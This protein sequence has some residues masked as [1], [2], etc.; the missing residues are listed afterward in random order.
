MNKRLS[1][2]KRLNH[3]KLPIKVK[4][5]VITLILL[6]IPMCTLGIMSF[7]KASTELESKGETILINAVNSSMQLIELA[8]TEVDS[9]AISLEE[10]QE[11][12]KTLLIGEKN[13]DGSRT[14]KKTIDLGGNGF[15]IILDKEANVL[16]H[17]EIEGENL[18][19]K[20][21]KSTT[22]ILFARELIEKGLN[23]GGFTEYNLD[24]AG[25]VDLNIVYSKVDPTWGWIVSAGTYEDN[26]DES[27]NYILNMMYLI[28]LLSFIIGTFVIIAFARHICNPLKKLTILVEKTK[29]LDLSNDDAYNK[30]IKNK[31][32]V[33]LMASS[34]LEMRLS[35]RSIVNN[36]K[37]GVEETFNSSEVL[38]IAANETASCS[39]DIANT[40]DILVEGAM[41]QAYESENGTNEL[42]ILGEEIHNTTIRV[43][44]VKEIIDLTSTVSEKGINLI[45]DLALKSKNKHNEST[46]VR[47][48]VEELSYKSS[49]IDNMLELITQIASQTNI[50]ALNASIE[51]AR[52]GEEGKGFTVVANEVKT[53]AETTDKTV[54]D[55]KAIVNEM[56]N[57]IKITEKSIE[58]DKEI[59]LHVGESL[60][61]VMDGFKDIN[62]SV[63]SMVDHI[64]GL[65][66]GILKIDEEKNTVIKSIES[67][68]DISKNTAQFTHK[69]KSTI[70]EQT[71]KTQDVSS[72][73]E[74]LDSI[75]K[76]LK[77]EINEFI[78]D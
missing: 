29:N 10:A 27:A 62:T 32:E 60:S 42:L 55:I 45:D 36:F 19:D 50:L 48:N 56:Q 74:N 73:A 41:N 28:I 21:D 6:I 72:M 7:T 67:I 18:W 31:D 16:A 34:I 64:N 22:P 59:E 1:K 14:L 25:K 78:I 46:I 69:I 17:D 65:N 52:A 68:S 2:E 20:T 71:V 39:D 70:E 66:S 43:D 77:N 51:A 57:C 11:K 8:Q 5:I 58:R 63:E 13:S 54:K 47:K 15:F 26:F 35:L 3:V 4:L 30:L 9:G 40:I 33:G 12:V 23:G 75:A 61:S 53:L 76:K 49:L 38:S 44:K 24:T 37:V